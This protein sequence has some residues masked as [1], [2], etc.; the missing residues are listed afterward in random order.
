M[1]FEILCLYQIKKNRET[2]RKYI[3]TIN[4]PKRTPNQLEQN[5]I[6]YLGLAEVVFNKKAKFKIKNINTK[7]LEYKVFIDYVM[8]LIC[9]EISISQNFETAKN[10]FYGI[11]TENDL[12]EFLTKVITFIWDNQNSEYPIKNCIDYEPKKAVFLTMN[13]ELKAIDDV[14]I[15]RDFKEKIKNEDLLIDIPKNKHINIDYRSKLLNE[16]LNQNLLKNKIIEKL[17]LI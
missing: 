9:E 14:L 2:I 16:Q 3:E 17:Y 7:N 1:A 10:K 4:Y 12:A 8:E 11:K 6:K 5:P 15:K 13:N